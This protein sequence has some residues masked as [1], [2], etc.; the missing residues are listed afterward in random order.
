MEQPN[1][2]IHPDLASELQA[3]C[4]HIGMSAV[5]CAN[6]AIAR[7]LQNRYDM[8]SLQPQRPALELVKS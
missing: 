2:H 1:I 7:W 4:Q 8:D 5:T 3:Y 6:E